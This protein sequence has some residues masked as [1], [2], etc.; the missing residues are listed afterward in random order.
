METIQRGQIAP[1]FRLPNAEGRE[2]SLSHYKQFHPL[3]LLLWSGADHGWLDDFA[4]RY[5]DYQRA[6]ANLLAVGPGFPASEGLPFQALQDHD[7]RATRRLAETLPAVLVLDELGEV[8]QPWQRRSAQSP[9]HADI[10]S[11]VDFTQV[12]CEE[13]GIMAPHW[14]LG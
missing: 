6:G 4:D 11:W 12:Q 9:D 7:G 14:D 1:T 10:L 13:C 3:V 2:V 8:F 5:P